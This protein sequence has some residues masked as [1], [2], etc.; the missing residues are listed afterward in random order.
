MG[1]GGRCDRS[2]SMICSCNGGEGNVA[3]VDTCERA[4]PK[5]S[6]LLG[7]DGEGWV[8]FWIIHSPIVGKRG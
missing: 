6:V 7:I 8:R 5:Q 4:L 3:E 1:D 2:K